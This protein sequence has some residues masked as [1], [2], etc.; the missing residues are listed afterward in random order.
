MAALGAMRRL[1]GSDRWFVFAIF[2]MTAWAYGISLVIYQIFGYLL[3]VVPFNIFT[4][5][6]VA[7]LI[8]FIV[9]LIRPS[10]HK[11]VS[12]SIPSKRID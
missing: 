8:L 5:V 10:K 9:L 2:Y 3:G 1:L 6:A 7:V 4:V 12:L 11:G